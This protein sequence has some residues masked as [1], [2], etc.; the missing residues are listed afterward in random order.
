MVNWFLRIRTVKARL[1][2][3]ILRS[4]PTDTMVH[5][6]VSVK[7]FVW[8]LIQFFFVFVFLPAV[9]PVEQR[10]D[11]HA[12]TFF[13]GGSRSLLS[14]DLWK[15]KDQQDNHLYHNVYHNIIMIFTWEQLR[16]DP[17]WQDSVWGTPTGWGRAAEGWKRIV[18]VRGWSGLVRLTKEMMT[19][20]VKTWEESDG[21]SMLPQKVPLADLNLTMRIVMILRRRRSRTKEMMLKIKFTFCQGQVKSWER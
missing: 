6:L 4:A 15:I 20:W 14:W 17:G 16:Q 1:C 5:Q 12:Q 13:S 18:M 2:F 11:S 8:C 21:E 3:S 19:S 7:M 9:R 10:S